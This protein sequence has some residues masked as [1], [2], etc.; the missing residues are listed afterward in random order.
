MKSILAMNLENITQ[1]VKNNLIDCQ[2]HQ[3]SSNKIKYSK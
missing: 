3:N 2:G 1:L